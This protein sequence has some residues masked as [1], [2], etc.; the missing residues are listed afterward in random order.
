MNLD[1]FA[2]IVCEPETAS[3]NLHISICAHARNVDKHTLK[4]REL[5]EG[6]AKDLK[7][8][9]LIGKG[10]LVVEVLVDDEY[11]EGIGKLAVPDYNRG[12]IITVI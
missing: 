8:S 10:W 9:K 4:L 1:K 2:E 12:R 3:E 11:C 5:W 7:N 6:K